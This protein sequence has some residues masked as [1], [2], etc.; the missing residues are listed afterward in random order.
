MCWKDKINV[1]NIFLR[2]LSQQPAYF[3]YQYLSPFNHIC[4]FCYA[5]GF[6]Y[7]NWCLEFHIASALTFQNDFHSC[8]IAAAWGAL[9][10]GAD[11]QFEIWIDHLRDESGIT[12]LRYR[13]IFLPRPPTICIIN[14]LYLEKIW[15]S[16][17][18]PSSHFATWR[19]CDSPHLIELHW[20]FKTITLNFY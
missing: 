16:H 19:R 5:E 9:D 17:I 2:F 20:M 13:G 12:L 15:K 3:L 10:N 18:A 6:K 4:E 1:Q 8:H 14:R 11:I 7:W